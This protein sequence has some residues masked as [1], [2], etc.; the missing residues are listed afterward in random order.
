MTKTHLASKER[1]GLLMFSLILIVT[2]SVGIIHYN[3]PQQ[4]HTKQI[5]IPLV[6]KNSPT[7]D[8]LPR[9][10]N[11]H[12]TTKAKRKKRSHKGE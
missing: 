2:V 7:S 12:K 3:M 10:E 8:T 4:N 1:R 9:I 5:V 6:P 11:R